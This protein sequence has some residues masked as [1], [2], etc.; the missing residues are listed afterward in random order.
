MWHTQM[1]H[2]VNET[3]TQMRGKAPWVLHNGR[4]PGTHD[5]F[6]CQTEQ[7]VSV[8]TVHR[9]YRVRTNRIEHQVYKVTQY[10]L[11]EPRVLT[12]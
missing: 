2:K 12:A 10:E 1:C 5:I 6:V 11:T 8:R 4:Y 9:T 3:L 7:E